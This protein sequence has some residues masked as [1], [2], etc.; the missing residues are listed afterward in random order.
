MDTRP[1]IPMLKQRLLNTFNGFGDDMMRL[2]GVGEFATSWPLF[3]QPPPTNYTAAL[4][5]VAKMGWSF[6]Q[7]SL[8]P[9]EDQLTIT[10]FESVNAT[11]PI[12]GLHWSIG[13]VPRIDLPTINRFKALGAGIAVHPF[14]YLAGAPG[15]GPPL[16]TIL[17][18]GIH[19]GAGSD[20]AQISTLDPWLMIYY[21]VT[22]KNSSGVVVNEG[23]QITR[24]EALRLYTAENGWFFREEDKLGTIE[25]GKL[26]DVAV[27]SDDYFDP[28]KVTDE[29]IKRLKAVLTVVDG[30][31]VH[32]ETRTSR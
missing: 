24:M 11:T 30:K 15:A 13:H 27:L 29:G 1:D 8:S 19:V 28:M 14:G 2:S 17:D 7:H 18:S 25:P 23:Q 9:A 12:A 6:Q 21:M 32:D 20:S 26:A 4:Q 3:G 16:R 22:G 10:T 5:L 31:V